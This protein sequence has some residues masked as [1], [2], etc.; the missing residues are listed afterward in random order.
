MVRRNAPGLQL[1]L[2]WVLQSLLTS[3][4]GILSRLGLPSLEGGDPDEDYLPEKSKLPG[5]RASKLACLVFP[6]LGQFD[7]S[8]DFYQFNQWI[9]F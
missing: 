4:A 9:L 5:L 2:S 7:L 3:V 1:G 8:A 6:F